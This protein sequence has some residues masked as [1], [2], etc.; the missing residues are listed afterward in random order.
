LYTLIGFWQLYTLVAQ[1]RTDHP[2]RRCFESMQPAAALPMCVG[3]QGKG[4]HD[5]DHTYTLTL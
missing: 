2:P 5:I 1:A 4:K 3:T